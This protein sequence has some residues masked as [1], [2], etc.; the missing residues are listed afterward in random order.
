MNDERLLQELENALVKLVKGGSALEVPYGKRIDVSEHMKKAYKNIDYERVQEL[1][2][3]ELEEAL[4]KK[5][6]NKVIT[7]MGN[8]IKS[9]MSNNSIREDFKYLM[10]KGVD[11]IMDRVKEEK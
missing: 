1:V 7:E 10:R 9:L 2:S 11:E 5:I 8:D 4:A 3:K 6:V